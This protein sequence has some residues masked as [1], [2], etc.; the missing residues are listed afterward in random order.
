[1]DKYAVYDTGE[2]EET[3]FEYEIGETIW[4]NSTITM[5]CKE[6]KVIDGQLIQYFKAGRL[7]F[8]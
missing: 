6:K 5:M 7:V 2:P 1:M 8:D 3:A 4:V